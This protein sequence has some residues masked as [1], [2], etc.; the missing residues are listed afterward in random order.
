MIRLYE[1]GW[2][3]LYQG[4]VTEIFW[5]EKY[6]SVLLQNRVEMILK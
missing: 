5:G 2:V 1:A 4:E 3:I 6:T